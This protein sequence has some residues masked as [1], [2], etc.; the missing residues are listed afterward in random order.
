MGKVV[1]L[2]EY[3]RATGEGVVAQVGNE[4][5]EVIDISVAGVRLSRPLGS[6]PRRN[7]EFRIIPVS[8]AGPDVH[9]AIPVSGHIVG[10]DCLHLRIAFAAVTTALAN[11]IGRYEGRCGASS[12]A[13]TPT[14]PL[15]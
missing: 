14:A 1:D 3:H 8:S 13:I 12:F 6:L 5:V 7:L 4:I 10:E 15:F 9:R 2:R 11:V